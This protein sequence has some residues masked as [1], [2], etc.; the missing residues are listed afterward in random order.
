MEAAWRFIE[1]CKERK[2]LVTPK[3]LILEALKPVPHEED[4]MRLGEIHRDELQKSDDI[5]RS[6]YPQI[7]RNVEDTSKEESPV[8]NGWGGYW[9][10]KT[11]LAFPN[12]CSNS[13]CKNEEQ[14]PKIVGAHVRK[15]GEPNT[16]KDAWIVPLCHKCNSDDNKEPMD[17]NGGTVFVR[18]HM[19]E[20]HK[21]ACPEEDKQ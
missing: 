15:D 3:E 14:N 20:S 8:Q 16:G 12:A 7:V 13:D 4:L 19:S 18:V 10:D 2:R 21:T 1:Q 17:L 11:W 6:D 5:F 9:Q